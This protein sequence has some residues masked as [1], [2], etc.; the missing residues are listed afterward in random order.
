MT[1][2]G[3]GTREGNETRSD[4]IGA[5]SG[6]QHEQERNLGLME[7]AAGGGAGPSSGAYN[8]ISLGLGQ[9]GVGGRGYVTRELRLY[10]FRGWQTRLES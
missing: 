2:D 7:R 1:H 4:T 3:W 6:G 8:K 9:R 10:G 5:L